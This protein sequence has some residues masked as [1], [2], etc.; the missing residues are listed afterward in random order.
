MACS[1]K[2]EGTIKSLTYCSIHLCLQH[3]ECK[4]VV[5]MVF[6]ASSVLMTSSSLEIYA[7]G[8]P[9]ISLSPGPPRAG[10]HHHHRHNIMMMTVILG[11]TELRL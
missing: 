8:E 4:Q 6:V 9:P 5:C 3:A 7:A 11:K 10:D 1:S 2:F